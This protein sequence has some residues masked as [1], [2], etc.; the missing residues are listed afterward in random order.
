[1]HAWPLDL[2]ED[3]RFAQLQ[4]VE[5]GWPGRRENPTMNT[6]RLRRGARIAASSS[7]FLFV[8]VLCSI[9]CLR[10]NFRVGAM[11]STCFLRFSC[12]NLIFVFLNLLHISSRV[13]ELSPGFFII[14]IFCTLF[15]WG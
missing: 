10:L 5:W 1:M 12:R 13:L 2:A 11:G 7:L 15:F 9:F 14:I 3:Y 6:P 8:V 4:G